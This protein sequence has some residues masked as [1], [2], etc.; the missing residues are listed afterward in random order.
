MSKLRARRAATIRG[1]HAEARRLAVEMYGERGAL[2]QEAVTARV[3][4]KVR[5]RAPEHLL[6]LILGSLERIGLTDANLPAT[7]DQCLAAG[8]ALFEH[9][10]DDVLYLRGVLDADGWPSMP[11]RAEFILAVF[12]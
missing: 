2:R 1:E 10:R 12:D 11:S 9:Y 6:D 3:R 7:C 5:K 4:A 8:W